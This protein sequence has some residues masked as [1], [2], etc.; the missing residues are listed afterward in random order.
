[1]LLDPNDGRFLVC[2]MVPEEPMADNAP[3]VAQVR[4]TINDLG[5]NVKEVLD[6]IIG[7]RGDVTFLE[8]ACL[9]LTRNREWPRFPAQCYRQYESLVSPHPPA[10]EQRKD[11]EQAGSQVV[12]D[13]YV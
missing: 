4:C 10:P 1:M 3:E 11:S 7:P 5:A 13:S 2:W 6:S 8:R 12:P 9:D